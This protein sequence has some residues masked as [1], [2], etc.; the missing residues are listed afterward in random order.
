MLVSEV[1]SHIPPNLRERTLNNIKFT[2]VTHILVA[3]VFSL[4]IFNLFSGL[5]PLSSPDETRYTSISAHM[6]QSGDYVTPKLNTIKFLDKPVL[7][8]WVQA[9]AMHYMGKHNWVFRLPSALFAALG[10]FFVFLFCL[11]FYSVKQAWLAMLMLMTAPLYFAMA[12]YVNMDIAIAV[13]ISGTLLAYRASTL[14]HKVSNRK[15]LLYLAYV[16][17]AL[18]VLTKGLIGFVLPGM[19]IVLWH[20]F[21]KDW[22]G[23]KNALCPF[24]ALLFIV[25]IAPWL[26][27]VQ[28]ANPDFFHYFFIFEQ[29]DRF[30]QSGFN[31]AMPFWFYIP[32]ILVGFL[33][34]LPLVFTGIKELLIQRNVK[35]SQDTLFYLC[36]IVSISLFFS[37][38]QSKIIS[39]I[40]PVF[41]PIAIL[42]AKLCCNKGL[43][44]KTQSMMK[45]LSPLL[46]LISAIAMSCTLLYV[47]NS[48]YLDNIR[49]YLV[50]VNALLY[51][52]II[53]SAYLAIYRNWQQQLFYVGFST[54]FIYCILLPSTAYW[55]SNNTRAFIP[56][57]E[58]HLKANDALIAYNLYP[59]ELPIYLNRAIPVV[60]NWQ[61]ISASKDNWKGH[62][63]YG[64]TPQ[65]KKNLLLSEQQ[66]QVLWHSNKHVYALMPKSEYRKLHFKNSIIENNGVD[67]LIENKPNLE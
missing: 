66:F 10:C 49:I 58:H 52:S 30:S 62:F 53:I 67:V 51:A 24:G 23:I 15:I 65:Q 12:H 57:L 6:L 40:L 17:A 39:Y 63:V 3:M 45:R 54:L 19:V 56:Y 20:S 61:S 16:C 25:I 31:N 44:E 47:W 59:Y 18:G 35:P 55:P 32:V 2:S 29:F 64:V 37:I 4:L 9:T 43:S 36:W 60:E 27:L 13:L 48:D 8:Y 14:A 34:W 38:P 26:Y 21:Q 28:K 50:M 33:P 1:T 5:R 7:Y 42:M 46:Y 41:P 22:V 11:K